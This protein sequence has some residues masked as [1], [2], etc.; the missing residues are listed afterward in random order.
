LFPIPPRRAVVYALGLH[1]GHRVPLGVAELGD[2]GAAF[3]RLGVHAHEAGV[4]EGQTQLAQLLR[5]IRFE[6]TENF[7][8]LPL[9]VRYLVLLL[10]LIPL[11]LLLLQ[12]S[13]EP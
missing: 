3:P 1:E 6:F 7:I 8:Y 12:L 13:E 5:E 11:P 10:L 4:S 2:D 9:D